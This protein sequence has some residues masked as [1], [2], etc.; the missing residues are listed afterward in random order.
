MPADV[1]VT[2][3]DNILISER[4]SPPLTTVSQNISGGGRNIVEGLLR[5]MRGQPCPDQISPAEL[6][7]RSSSLPLQKSA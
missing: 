5:Q 2:G 3:F 6:L 7:V 1:S 4:A